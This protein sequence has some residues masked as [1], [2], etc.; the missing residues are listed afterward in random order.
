MLCNGHVFALILSILLYLWDEVVVQ[1]QCFCPSPSYN[2]V[3]TQI[4]LECCETAIILSSLSAFCRSPCCHAVQ[5]QRF[6][7]CHATA[8][9]FPSS[10]EFCPT[11]SYNAVQAQ[12]F[13]EWCVTAIFL[14][15]F[16]H[17]AL[18]TA[19]ML[20]SLKLFWV[21]EQQPCFCTHSQHFA[22]HP[23][24]M[25]CNLKFFGM[26]WSGHPLVFIHG[27]VDGAGGNF[28][29]VGVSYISSKI[30]RDLGSLPRS[31]MLRDFWD[32]ECRS[33]VWFRGPGS[34]WRR[35]S[36]CDWGV[37][38]VSCGRSEICGVGQGQGGLIPVS[39]WFL[40]SIAGVWRL[41]GGLGARVST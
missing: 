11:P 30:V 3:Q 40:A 15:S 41:E 9:F 2:A 22:L 21:D 8:M 17:F 1:W 34:G 33:G 31:A 4:V 36:A 12:N 32:R 14:P 25:L 10:S 5:A 19:L 38:C 29:G 16:Q 28:L 26:L 18:P 7:E 39:E 27:I 35:G 6:L 24:A 13:L 20:R 37:L 23:A